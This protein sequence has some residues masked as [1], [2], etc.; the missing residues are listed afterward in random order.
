MLEEAQDRGIALHA[1]PRSSR[2][3][4]SGDPRLA[5][6]A[7][8]AEDVGV[9]HAELRCRRRIDAVAVSEMCEQALSGG[10]MMHP[11]L[12][13][14]EVRQRLGVALPGLLRVAPDNPLET[15]VL[16]HW[17]RLLRTPSPPATR[18][19]EMASE[20]RASG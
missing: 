16:G 7:V 8:D 13:A 19:Y 4:R 6:V 17:T 10:L 1:R 2:R 3:E 11:P 18:C 12:E 9:V 15:R 14:L 5:V 20:R